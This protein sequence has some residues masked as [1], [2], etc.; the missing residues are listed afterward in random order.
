MQQGQ[1]SDD[2]LRVGQWCGRSDRLKQRD[3]R[4]GSG[5]GGGVRGVGE[6]GGEGD[7][8]C[9]ALFTAY[10]RHFSPPFLLLLPR[11]S[12]HSPGLQKHQSHVSHGHCANCEYSSG[13]FFAPLAPPRGLKNAAAWGAPGDSRRGLLPEHPAVA[14]NPL[15]SGSCDHKQRICGCVFVPGFPSSEPGLHSSGVLGSVCL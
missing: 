6:V 2:A 3:R 11:R 5:R 9:D 8:C 4:R 12:L 10:E 7:S 14:F 1:H 15:G 13:Y